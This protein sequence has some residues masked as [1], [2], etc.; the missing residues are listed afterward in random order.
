MPVYR[1]ENLS[2]VRHNPNLSSGIGETIK[3]D[4]MFFCHRI[5]A[6]GTKADP[7]HHPCE[8]FIYMLRGRQKFTIE[9][10]VFDVGPGD[11]VH[12]PASAVHSTIIEEEVEAVYVKDTAWGLKGVPAGEKAPD[13]PPEDDPF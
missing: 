4:R 1:F 3:G 13:T 6:T 8:Q 5:W 10:E 2:A 12:V 11:V 9:G 7:H